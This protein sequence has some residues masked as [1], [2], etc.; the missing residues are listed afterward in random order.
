MPFPG[1]LPSQVSSIS[2]AFQHNIPPTADFQM[3]QSQ[4]AQSNLPSASQRNPSYLPQAASMPSSF[5][6]QPHPPDAQQFLLPPQDPRALHFPDYYIACANCSNLQDPDL[7]SD[8]LKCTRR[9]LVCIRCMFMHGLPYQRCPL[10]KER[11]LGLFEMEV[12]RIRYASLT[13]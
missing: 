7:F 6:A 2:S 13:S 4:S 10:C 12:I 1:S 3:P 9:C 11:K 8:D 5:F